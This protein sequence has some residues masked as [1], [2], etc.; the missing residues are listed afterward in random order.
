MK[1][2]LLAFSFVICSSFNQQADEK[3]YSA[4]EKICWK[5]DDSGNCDNSDLL[6]KE[7]KWFHE[8][9]L[10]IRGDSV[11]LDKT[12]I[13]KIGNKTY[14]SASDGAFYYYRGKIFRNE[15]N[16]IVLTEI[17]CDYCAQPVEKNADGTYTKITR[18]LYGK[19]VGDQIEIE[20][21]KYNLIQNRKEKLLSEYIKE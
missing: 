17:S 11:F 2:F 9:I 8:N 21:L 7:Q 19:V 14:Y 3:T 4:L 1:L 15:Q 16:K 12:P 18:R 20:G 13:N 5:T 10:K 6:N